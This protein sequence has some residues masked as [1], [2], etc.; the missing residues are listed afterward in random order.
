MKLPLYQVDAFTDRAFGGNPA[1]VVPLESWLDAELMQNIACE[2]NLAETAFFV[3][4]AAADHWE[5]RWFTPATEVPL[6]GHATLA[7]AAVIRDQLGHDSWPITFESASGPLVVERDGDALILD[8]PANTPAPAA[9]PDGLAEALG[10]A[11]PETLSATG[12]L[13]AVFADAATVACLE[14]D[15][16][17][18]VELGGQGVIATA[19]GDDVDFVSRF[20][21]PAI[22]IDEDPVTGAAHCVLTP[23]W[24]ARLEKHRLEAVQLSRRRGYLG[25]ELA[26]ER[27]RLRGHSVFYL[28]GE[29]SVPD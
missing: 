23:Y 11:V 4:G 19:P 17:R 3:P 2:N 14:P 1:A 12:F 24:S 16:A 10:S 20:F 28:G 29:I 5:L 26:G 9:T 15:F 7:S 25:C 13:V 18:L 27:V 22:G 21:A 6:C 8:F